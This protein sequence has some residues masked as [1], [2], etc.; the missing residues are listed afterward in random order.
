VGQ[1]V[2]VLAI[3]VV[4]VVLVVVVR[5]VEAQVAAVEAVVEEV[6]KIYNMT[7]KELRDYI[8]KQIPAEEALLR[9]LEG[10]LIEYEQLKFSDQAQAIHPVILISMAA[11][12][13]GWQF[14]V[15]TQRD[16]E[17]VR[18]LVV[19]TEEYMNKIFKHE[20]DKAQESK[21]EPEDGSGRDS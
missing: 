1:A 12:D 18:G 19:G 17:P 11:M 2:V 3:V 10:S 16:N 9:L 6:I 15:E 8:L 5:D 21:V 7:A 20:Q 13:M 14:A 4:G